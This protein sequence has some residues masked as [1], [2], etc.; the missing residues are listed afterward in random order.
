MVFHRSEKQ[1]KEKKC[2]RSVDMFGA[3]CKIRISFGDNA[4]KHE[5][6]LAE[7]SSY[8]KTRETNCVGAL[9]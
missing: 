3:G 2:K 4:N 5:R 9:D 7:A 8:L 1:K 6:A